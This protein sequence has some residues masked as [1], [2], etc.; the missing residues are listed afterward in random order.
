M[1]HVDRTITLSKYISNKVSVE[2]YGQLLLFKTI[3]VYSIV[4]IYFNSRETNDTL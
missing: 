1:P 4:K 3:I 2:I